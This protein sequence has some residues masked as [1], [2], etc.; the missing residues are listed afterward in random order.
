MEWKKLLS[1][2]VDD[3]REGVFDFWDCVFNFVGTIEWSI[4]TVLN[5]IV[6][7]GI[8]TQGYYLSRYLKRT[9]FTKEGPNAA[10]PYSNANIKPNSLEPKYVPFDD[11]II[12]AVQ[13]N[14]SLIENRAISERISTFLLGQDIRT[15]EPLATGRIVITD[16]AFV[17]EGDKVDKRIPWNEIKS[18]DLGATWE[19][20][21]KITLKDGPSQIYEI[22]KKDEKM[23][24]K[25]VV[26][27]CE[28]STPRGYK[29]EKRTIKFR[30]PNK[31]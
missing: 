8:I 17:F 22:S 25:F 19:S 29:P 1:E 24:F 7:L 27:L 5:T 16:K 31:K 9:M 28:L 21:L 15:L 26:Y 6:I 13:D 3:F 18:S 30:T 12:M 11:E 20:Y 4:T 2:G 23:N 10:F 14:I